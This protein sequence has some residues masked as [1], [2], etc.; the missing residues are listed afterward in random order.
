M[1]DLAREYETDHVKTKCEQYISNQLDFDISHGKLKTDRL[2]LFLATCGQ[3]GLG[4]TQKRL[5]KLAAEKS[6][7]ELENCNNITV[8]PPAILK[9]VFLSRCKALEKIES[10]LRRDNDSLVDFIQSVERI[11]EFRRDSVSCSINNKMWDVYDLI[12]K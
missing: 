5:V 2:F 11:T 1:L 12:T 7:K 8:V 3:H 6:C 4:K 10:R 9:E